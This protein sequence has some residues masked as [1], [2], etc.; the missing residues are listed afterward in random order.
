MN[1]IDYYKLKITAFNR[2][3]YLDRFKKGDFRIFGNSNLYIL[4]KALNG[5][6]AN[7]S[8][9]EISIANSG[10]HKI[11]CNSILLQLY[12]I[13]FYKQRK[14]E[15][16]RLQDWDIADYFFPYSRFSL[17]FNRVNK[18]HC[19]ILMHF[20]MYE[21]FVKLYTFLK[22]ITRLD[23][24]EFVN[25]FEFDTP[26]DMRRIF[27]ELPITKRELESVNTKKLAKDILLGKLNLYELIKKENP[28]QY[29]LEKYKS[30][31]QKSWIFRVKVLLNVLAGY[32]SDEE[33]K[34]NFDKIWNN[35][36]VYLTIPSTASNYTVSICDDTSGYTY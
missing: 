4:K 5:K 24:E 36:K 35:W 6:E 17:E 11:L 18:L 19:Y 22:Y 31:Y 29:I 15:I 27:L 1:E 13:N 32:T 2:N 14:W 28:T 23:V 16:D 10:C 9:A 30:P 33:V 26:H 3:I 8:K 34:T 21:E 20:S 25:R 7:N 12:S